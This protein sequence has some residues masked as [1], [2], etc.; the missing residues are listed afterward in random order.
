MQWT[1]L[2]FYVVVGVPLAIVAF[3]ILLAVARVIFGL[4]GMVIIGTIAATATVIRALTK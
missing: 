3:W 2:L 1:E 4:L